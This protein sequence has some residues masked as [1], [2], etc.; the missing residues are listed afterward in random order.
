MYLFLFFIFHFPSVEIP[1]KLHRRAARQVHTQ[2]I[3][4]TATAFCDVALAPPQKHVDFE[5]F[6]RKRYPCDL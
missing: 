1:A 4:A 2:I 3:V 6:A 5:R